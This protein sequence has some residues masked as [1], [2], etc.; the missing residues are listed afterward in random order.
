MLMPNVSRV[1]TLSCCKT[2]N[3]AAVEFEGG[4]IG[5]GSFRR[6]QSGV[7]EGCSHLKV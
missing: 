5:S 3:L 1:C 2:Q 4:F 6:L 7:S